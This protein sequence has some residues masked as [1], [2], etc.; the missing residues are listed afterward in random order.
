MNLHGSWFPRGVG[1]WSLRS[2]W[3][4]GLRDSCQQRGSR[5][6][7]LSAPAWAWLWAQKQ[8]SLARY[9]GRSAGAHQQTQGCTGGTYR[10]GWA[11]SS[12]SV[13][14]WPGGTASE[15]DRWRWGKVALKFSRS[16][17]FGFACEDLASG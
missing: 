4:P 2:S 14:E 10:A 8:R 16:S 7:W 12:A 5:G 11:T 13:S 17:S 1:S 15:C 9:H 3:S 6:Y